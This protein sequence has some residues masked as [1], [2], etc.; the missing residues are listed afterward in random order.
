M[1][2]GLELTAQIEQRLLARN[3]VLESF[4]ALEARAWRK[5]AAKCLSAFFAAAGCWPLGVG[6]TPPTRN[7]SPSNSCI[8]SS[9]GKRALPAARSFSRV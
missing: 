9:S 8:P 2:T 7:T 5:L 6:P 1:A 3:Q 4:F